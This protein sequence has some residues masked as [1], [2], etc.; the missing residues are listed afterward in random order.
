MLMPATHRRAVFSD[1]DEARLRG[2]ASVSALDRDLDPGSAIVRAAIAKAD[3]LV[4]GT[5]SP[6][7]PVEALA[8]A[9]RLR[10][11][12]HTAGSLRPIVGEDVYDLGL[13]LSS[14]AAANALPVA[15]YALAMILLEL[16]GVRD[17]EQRY[18]AA[19]AEIDVDALLAARGVF[20]RT[21]GVVGASSIG[22][23][24]VELLR[25]FDVE[26]MLVDPFLDAREAQR[27]GARLA[28]LDEVFAD[29]DLVSLH[30]PLLPETRGMVTGTLLRR[31]RAGSVFV[32]TARGA[33]VDQDALI[34]VVR[35]GRIR[36]VIDVTDPEV[37]PPD[38]PLWTLDGVVLTPHVAGSR[39][40]E[41]R[42]IGGRAVDEI[43][44]LLRGEALRYGVP[45][46]RYATNA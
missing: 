33:L 12:V 10:G 8:A 3:V 13:E 20:G 5:G 7:L 25:P 39:G 28:S 21:V 22:R 9:E 30:A 24:V 41:L 23:R 11:I 19:R 34:E 26:V 32:N 36:A 2:M 14:H 16:K 46:E 15:E 6:F 38:S 31:M 40:L 29:A 44:R 27:L 17:A 37:L 4:T 18:R 42:R 45:R 35:S 1:D 43:G